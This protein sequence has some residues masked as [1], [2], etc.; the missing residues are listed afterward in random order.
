MLY[1]LGTM[2]LL[3]IEYYRNPIRLELIRHVLPLVVF[4]AVVATALGYGW[5]KTA[6]SDF[7]RVNG[8]S[9]SSISKMHYPQNNLI[10]AATAPPHYRLPADLPPAN[11]ASPEWRG[12][13]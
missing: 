12:P 7:N 2:Q 9:I 11:R 5:A 1:N 10:G 8:Q 3:N 4:V 13:R 6:Y